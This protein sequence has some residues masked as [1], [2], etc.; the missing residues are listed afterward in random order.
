MANGRGADRLIGALLCIYEQGPM[1]REGLVIEIGKHVRPNEA[2]RGVFQSRRQGSASSAEATDSDVRAGKRHLALK[3]LGYAKRLKFL[4]EDN[5]HTV[6]L[7]NHGLQKLILERPEC[8]SLPLDGLGTDNHY[9][10]RVVKSI[11]DH[12]RTSNSYLTRRGLLES[13][14]IIHRVVRGYK[15]NS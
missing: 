4:K 9:L 7:T 15:V 10:E 6:T 3:T 11:Q 14:R 5:E 8:V 1:N 12:L 2:V 13:L